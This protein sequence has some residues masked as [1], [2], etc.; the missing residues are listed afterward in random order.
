MQSLEGVDGVIDVGTDGF[1]F[2]ADMDYVSCSSLERL[3]SEGHA[4]RCD[5]YA[6]TRSSHTQRAQVASLVGSVISLALSLFICCASLWIY[7]TPS[8]RRHLDRVSFRLF[9]WS[10]GVEVVYNAAYLYIFSDVSPPL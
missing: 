4:A 1:I 8:A 10:M 5:L 2:N 3:V 9:L 7:R 6:R